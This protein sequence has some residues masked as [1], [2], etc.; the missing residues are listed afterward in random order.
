MEANKGISYE[1]LK[2][3]IERANTT[4]RLRIADNWLRGNETISIPQYRTL[5]DIWWK[6]GRKYGTHRIIIR[7]GNVKHTYATGL[8]YSEAY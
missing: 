7:A 1:A 6:M 5:R 3:L 2:G 4:E 8:T